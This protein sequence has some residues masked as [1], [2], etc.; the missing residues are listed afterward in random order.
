M[1]A[2]T[3]VEQTKTRGWVT[4]AAGVFIVV[5]MSGVWLFVAKA[6]AEHRVTLDTPNTAK[7]LGQTY[8]AFGL[9]VF[10]G[11]LGIA[12]GVVQLRTRRRNISLNA[13]ILMLVAAAVVIIWLATSGNKS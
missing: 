12:N 11:I 10:S 6:I 13:L 2:G 9:I 7:F 1:T 3:D 5:L 8:M 4:I